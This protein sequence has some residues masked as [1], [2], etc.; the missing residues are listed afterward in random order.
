MP[1]PSP[2]LNQWGYEKLLPQFKSRQDYI[3]QVKPYRL[4]LLKEMIEKNAPSA[5]VAHGKGYWQEYKSLFNHLHFTK[6]KTFEVAQSDDTVVILTGQFAHQTMNGKFDEVANIIS[7][8]L[9]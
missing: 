5:I 7:E 9:Q 1:I 8:H 6:H 3:A 4:A 2:K